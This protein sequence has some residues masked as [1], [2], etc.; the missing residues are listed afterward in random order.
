M[1]EPAEK[2]KAKFFT[3]DVK[4]IIGREKPFK[5][6]SL[7][8]QKRSFDNEWIQEYELIYLSHRR[9]NWNLEKAHSS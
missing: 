1:E 3:L 8:D 6:K 7:N 2:H 9:E 5:N 4:T